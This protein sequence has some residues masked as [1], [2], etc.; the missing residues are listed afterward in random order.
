MLDLDADELAQA[1]TTLIRARI[2]CAAGRLAEALT[3][4]EAI[5]GSLRVAESTGGQCLLSKTSGDIPLNIHEAFQWAKTFYLAEF[6]TESDKSG[7]LRIQIEPL[8][9]E[10]G[11]A[12]APRLIHPARLF[13]P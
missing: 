10:A 13:I 4:Y 8:V 7:Y 5:L 3:L 6:S 9:T 1:Y 11:K 2:A 12:L